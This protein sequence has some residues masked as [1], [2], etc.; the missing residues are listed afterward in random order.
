MPRVLIVE[1]NAVNRQML[2]RR[3]AARGFTVLE[4]DTGEAGVAAAA[5]APPD[6][7][8]MDLG[9]PGIDG[10]EATRRIK[11]DPRSSRV[12]VIGLSAHAQAAD[13]EK[14]LAAG[15]CEFETKPVNMPVLL[16]KL[17]AVLG[18]APPAVAQSDDI[19]GDAPL[20]DPAAATGVLARIPRPAPPSPPPA[21]VPV[22]RK[23]VLVAE[24]HEANRVMLC[25]R[26]EKAGL[27]A[28][29]AEDGTAALAALRADGP[30]DL[31]LLDVM[32]PGLDGYAVL[33]EVK[34]DP[35]LAAVPVVMISAL[36]ETASVARCIEA[37]AE[38][39]LTKP[40][41]PVILFARVNACLDKR[42]VRDSE[43]SQLRAVGLLAAAAAAVE[44]GEFDP[45]ALAGLAVQP[46]ELGR[47]AR[48][49][50]RMA[51]EVQA[52]EQTLRREVERLRVVVDERR[53]DQQVAE[54]T[55]TSYF[56]QLQVR[57]AELRRR[58][59]G[60]A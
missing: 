3:L 31:L 38:D 12:P 2:G 10:C 59:P 28:V 37:G 50:V 40:Y 17:D 33:A 24:D 52:R 42:R 55:D 15:C 57:A 53:K 5:A 29:G 56:Q 35:A 54:L 1:D 16:A 32:M 46:D 20:V 7:V 13:R 49:F 36:D 39:Y 41:D 51:A 48:V 6:A 21:T 27:Q 4:A 9:L 19:F 45:A 34:A 47:L 18:A 43:Q 23:R 26:L 44:R 8:L 25:R 58:R 30:F 11:A 60:G 22:G 14:A